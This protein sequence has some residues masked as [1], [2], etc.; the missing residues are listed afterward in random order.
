MS[1]KPEKELPP[2]SEEK[3]PEEPVPK[4]GNGE[5]VGQMDSTSFSS[6]DASERP[7]AKAE[8][9]KAPRKLIVGGAM[10]K[11]GGPSIAS[12]FE[13]L[14]YGEAPENTDALDAWMKRHNDSD[15]GL[16]I[17]NQWIYPDDC[18][19]N[20]QIA[21]GTGKPFYTVVDVCSSSSSF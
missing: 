4:E 11:P 15:L 12:L 6:S 17:D 14:D 3:K 20:P 9:P 21:P 19:R 8:P 10:P 13:K 7:T 18:P 2:A 1:S 16:F 5:S